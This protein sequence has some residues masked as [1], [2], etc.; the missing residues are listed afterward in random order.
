MLLVYLSGIL[1][2]AEFYKAKQ[3]NP[4]KISSDI[5]IFF[6]FFTVINK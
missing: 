1:Q 5:F 6:F 3:R 4:T 2:K